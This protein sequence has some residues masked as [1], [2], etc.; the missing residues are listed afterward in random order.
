MRRNF[1]GLITVIVVIFALI[2]MSMV[3]SLDFD[4]PSENELAPN[5]STYNSGPTGT[6]ALYQLLEES[7]TPVSRWR[8]HYSQLQAQGND[9]ILVII[10]PFLSGQQI[11]AEDTFMLQDWL[12]SGG[13]ALIISRSPIEQFADSAIRSKSSKKTSVGTATPE[14]YIDEDSDLLIAQPTELTRE[15]RGLALSEFA[16]RISFHPE[17]EAGKAEEKAA[18]DPKQEPS[19]PSVLKDPIE[20][21]L[22]PALQAPII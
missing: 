9:A 18:A 4:P 20:D 12:S 2:M 3:G 8:S 15:L 22:E 16:S 6:R 5:R 14:Q 17:E 10:G 1:A 11:S 21:Y 7:G 13:R 19:D